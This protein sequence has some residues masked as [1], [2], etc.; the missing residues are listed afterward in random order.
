MRIRQAVL[1]AIVSHARHDYP[2]ECCGLIL[3]DEGQIAEAVAVTNVAGDPHRRYE[4]SPAEHI[5]QIKKCRERSFSGS[6]VEIVGVYHSHPHT[7][8]EPSPTDLREAWP[9]FL[10]VIAGPVTEHDDIPVRGFLLDGTIFS[11]VALVVMTS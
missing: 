7:P 4:L 2:N 11:E 6:H 5:A 8:A 9:N 1:D 3:G 10:Y